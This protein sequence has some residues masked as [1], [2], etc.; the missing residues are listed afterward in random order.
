MSNSSRLRYDFTFLHFPFARGI[1]KYAF[2]VSRSDCRLTIITLIDCIKI[3]HVLSW[4]IKID[5]QVTVNSGRLVCTSGQCTFPNCQSSSF[6]TGHCPFTVHQIRCMI[7]KLFN[8]KESILP[9]WVN[10]ITRTTESTGRERDWRICWTVLKAKYRVTHNKWQYQFFKGA[11]A[12]K[13]GLKRTY[14]NIWFR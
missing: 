3:D 8:T 2:F 10:D 11:R 5:S 13:I 14:L 7:I 12:Q 9:V 6:T 4:M 1:R